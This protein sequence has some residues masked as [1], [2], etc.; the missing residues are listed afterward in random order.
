MISAQQVGFFNVGSGRVVGKIQGSGL[1]RSV[2]MYKQVVLFFWG[3]FRVYWISSLFL[4]EVSKL[5]K[6]DGSSGDLEGI[7][8]N[9]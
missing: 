6:F 2:E 1:D 4:V 5:L 3:Y 9:I 7:H 8:G